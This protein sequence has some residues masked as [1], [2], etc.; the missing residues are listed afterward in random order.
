MANKDY[1]SK[2]WNTPLDDDIFTYVYENMPVGVCI[3]DTEGRILRMNARNQEIFGLGDPDRIVGFCIFDDTNIGP[4]DLVLMRKR[5][6]YS[7][8]YTLIPW[9]LTSHGPCNL[10]GE[11]HLFCRFRKVFA[12]NGEH[13]GYILVNV[14]MTE[15]NNQLRE[16]ANLLS[17]QL[18]QIHYATNMMTWRWD[19]RT[20]QIQA[21]RGFAP[22][23]LS[24][25]LSGLLNT[26][27]G[28][29]I[30]AINPD[31]RQIFMEHYEKLVS[32]ETDAAEI[33]V[34]MTFR[35]SGL[36][37]MWV[38][39]SGIISEFDETGAPLLMIG[40]TRIIESQ[41]RM[42][43]DLRLAKEKAE[44]S[45]KMK[46]SFI[47]HMNHEIRTPLNAIIGNS[48]VISTFHQ[49]LSENELNE[50]AKG[51][52]QNSELMMELVSN[53]LYLSQL[54]SGTLEVNRGRFSAIDLCDK[55]I[56]RNLKRMNEGVQLVNDYRVDTNQMINSDLNLLRV[57][58]DNLLSNAAKFTKQGEVRLTTTKVNGKV[59]IAVSDT[60]TGIEADHLRRLFDDFY[61]ADR[62]SQGLGIG[63][64]LCKGI[65]ELLGS[66]LEVESTVGVGST[67]KFLI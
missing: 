57:V 18:Q 9:N 38:H 53:M 16:E 41:K 7:Y 35:D 22:S 59:Q 58:L 36:P 1:N 66:K 43:E 39:F 17:R 30:S 51:I 48:D 55:L 37:E 14:D 31:D 60:G 50:L 61:K 24:A 25:H 52:R 19:L 49:S 63:L 20:G 2:V 5:N 28:E 11:R 4:E 65:I 64:S 40:S 21:N 34:R 44:Q 12:V 32:K 10:V 27:V 56:S 33:E 46:T 62:F 54:N 47:E 42:E 26:N 15:V 29:L 23:A 3:C 8:N 6:D 13:V 67:F 45:D